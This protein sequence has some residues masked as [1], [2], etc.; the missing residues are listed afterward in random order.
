MIMGLYLGIK[1]Y[2]IL[3]RTCKEIRITKGRRAKDNLMKVDLF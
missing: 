2:V 1:T 3:K